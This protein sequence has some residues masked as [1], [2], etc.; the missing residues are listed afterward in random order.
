MEQ[1][2]ATHLDSWSPYS[3]FDSNDG[4]VATPYEYKSWV[5]EYLQP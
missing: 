1:Y 2:T 4:I 5:A 3:Y